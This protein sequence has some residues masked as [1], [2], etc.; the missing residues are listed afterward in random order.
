MLPD[1]VSPS[2]PYPDDANSMVGIVKLVNTEPFVSKSPLMDSMNL[3]RQGCPGVISI[4]SAARAQL[5]RAVE[6]NSGSLSLRSALGDPRSV[7][8]TSSPPVRPPSVMECPTCPRKASLMCSSTMD[9]IF[10]RSPATIERSWKLTA[11]TFPEAPAQVVV[12]RAGIRMRFWRR[13]T[14]T[15]RPSSSH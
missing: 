9:K 5:R 7:V 12:G 1:L 13:F 6:M 10:S 3:L 2:L 8:R 11:H 15:R 14:I 4:K